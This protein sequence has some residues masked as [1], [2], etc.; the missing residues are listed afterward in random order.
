[1]QK[2]R[3]GG[4]SRR[5]A[6]RQTGGS[7][8]I[9]GFGWRRQPLIAVR[10]ASDNWRARLALFLV[11]LG[12][13]IVLAFHHVPWRDEGRAWSLMLMERSWPDM[14]RVVQ[15]EGHPYLWYILLRAGW[16]LFG[17]PLV[18]QVTALVIGIA[19]TALL[20]M[21]GPFRLGILALMIFSLHLG[22]EYTVVA[23]NYGISALIMLAIAALWPRIRDSL[24]LGVLLALLCNTNVPSVFIAGALAFYRLLELWE[25]KPDI[26][27][28]EWRRFLGNGLLLIAGTILCFVAVYPPANT[29]AAS[30]GSAPLTLANIFAALFTAERSFTAIGFGSKAAIGPWVVLLS[31]LILRD[32]PKA[33]A[34]ALIAFVIL[35]LFFYFV[36][37]GSFRH[38]ALFFFLIFALLWI[39]AG[40]GWKLILDGKNSRPLVMLGTTAFIILLSLQTLRYFKS[41]V[42]SLFV[43]RPYSEAAD[44]GEIMKEPQ[45]KGSWLMIDPDTMGEA[46][47]FQTGRPYW[48]TR[49][50]RPGTVTPLALSGNKRLTLDR[51]LE[52]ATAIQARTG[53]P[54]V[55]ALA[56]DIDT[57]PAGAYDMMYHDYTVLAPDAVA[58][59]KARTR[60][61][62]SLR[63]AWSDENY[64]VYVYPR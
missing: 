55:I 9:K 45:F 58:R 5:A 60:K 15:G 51:L 22:F 40:K 25:E 50:D 27:A 16:D 49:Q 8:A 52:Q 1:M 41:P 35:K 28:P 43:D 38:V 30:T 18:L 59:F 36:Y 54:V 33:L 6:A 34:T 24:W 4:H 42:G 26:R 61:L 13:T 46:V 3:C 10:P 63:R 53:R 44:L 14:F 23:R 64:D 56:L 37:P 7:V 48:L 11:W 29:A 47:V 21:R 62:A 19:A 32:R 31:L 20:V 17:T 12:V 39:E 57:T 2:K